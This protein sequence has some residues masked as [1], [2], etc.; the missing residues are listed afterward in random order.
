MIE[1]KVIGVE[2]ANA[3]LERFAAAMRDPTPANRQASIALYGW[4]LRNFD[5]QGG[6]GVPWAPLHPKTVRQKQKIGKEQPLV[7]TGQLRA[8]FTQGYS[9]DNAFV[10]NK[11]SYSKFHHEGTSRLPQRELLPRREVVLDIGLKVYGQYVAREAAKAN[12]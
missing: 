4:T 10:G 5:R 6:I 3:R 8:N 1:A 2:K 9:R 7:R 11:I 12:R